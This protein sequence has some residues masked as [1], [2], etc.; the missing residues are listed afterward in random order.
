MENAN[1][2]FLLIVYFQSIQGVKAEGRQNTERSSCKRGSVIVWR[3]LLLK[4]FSVNLIVQ[5]M[6]RDG[7]LAGLRREKACLRGWRSCMF[8]TTLLSSRDK[9]NIETVS[10][11]NYTLFL[12]DPY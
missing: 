8:Q 3:K 6:D 1:P 9:L 10:D 2:P 4:H 7:A 5:A 11:Y 12:K